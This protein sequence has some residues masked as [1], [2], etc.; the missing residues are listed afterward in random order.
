MYLIEGWVRA[1]VVGERQGRGE[2][3][4]RG[5]CQRW[6]GVGGAI[7]TL[8]FRNLSFI[9]SILFKDT[10]VINKPYVLGIREKTFRFK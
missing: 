10:L 3:S 5:D 2:H 9:S 4:L 1:V 7:S 6:I 8:K